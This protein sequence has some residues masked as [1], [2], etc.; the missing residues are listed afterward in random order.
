MTSIVR[1][2]FLD[3]FPQWICRPPEVQKAWSSAI[4]TLEG[5]SDVVN[6]VTFSPDG[7]LLASG[8]SD[9]TVRLWDA[10]TGAS[11]G[12]LEGHSG[13]V[14]AVACS[15]DGELLA[16]GSWDKTINLWDSTT[17]ASLVIL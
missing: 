4:Q 6:T 15:P 13:W 17:S 5:H 11:R 10:T 16:S 3:Q 7:K 2:Q 8:S 14:Y 12:I 1:E 9:N